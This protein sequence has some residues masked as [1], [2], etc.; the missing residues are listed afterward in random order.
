MAGLLA[1]ATYQ[2]AW[3]DRW[4]ALTLLL[5]FFLGSCFCFLANDLFDREKDIANSKFR[6]IAT[7][8]LPVPI[9]LIALGLSGIGFLVIGFLLNSMMLIFA[10]LAIASFL[11][12]SP[13]NSALGLIANVVVAFWA[14]APIWE[15]Q[16]V[17]ENGPTW[18]LALG[19]FFMVIVREILLD[20]L[21]LV[22]DE[23]VGK[24][25]LPI[26]LSESGLKGILL[27]L[28]LIGSLLIANIGWQLSVSTTA[29]I[30]FLLS[31]AIAWVPFV[32]LFRAFDR[33]T[34]LFNIRFTHLSF[35]VFVIALFLR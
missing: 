18:W 3:A 26:T 19:L 33:K 8:E 14:V 21:D 7:G 32:L 35:A 24:P 15:M 27:F 20:W 17:K 10:V 4:I 9:V 5:Y 16:F 12:Y 2:P 31:A 30:L 13:I 6:P 23:K 22:G 29:Q 34:V 28:M 25:S 11:V 1:L